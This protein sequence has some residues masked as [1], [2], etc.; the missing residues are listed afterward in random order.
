MNVIR[1]AIAEGAIAFAPDRVRTTGLGSCVG[2]VLYEHHKGLSGLVHVML[3]SAPASGTDRPTKYGELAVDWLRTQLCE[4]G[5]NPLLLRAKIA[6]GAQM[7]SN[8]LSSDVLRVGPRNVEAV[9]AAL[10]R[11]QIPI[12][13][14]DVGGHIGRTIEFEP[15]T[16]VLWVR[17]A[18]QG[19][20]AI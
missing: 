4:A 7:F 20:Y 18:F 13:A 11:L 8:Q 1:V 17:T 10:A 19:A 2:V 15:E 6:G 14:S 9:T 12:T 5:A 16:E 3:P